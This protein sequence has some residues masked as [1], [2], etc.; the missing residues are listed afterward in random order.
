MYRPINFNKE[1]IR[2]NINIKLLKLKVFHFV[3]IFFFLLLSYNPK[4]S[5]TLEKKE[6]SIYNTSIDYNDQNKLFFIINSLSYLQS[7]KYNKIEIKYNINVYNHKNE[8]IKPSDLALY[9][10]SNIV[11]HINSKDNLTNIIF[12]ADIYQNYQFSCRLYINFNR[13]HFK[14]GIKIYLKN[15]LIQTKYFDS[16]NIIDYNNLFYKN[17]NIFDPL[18]I[19]K[20]YFYSFK[21]KP[22]K[23]KKLAN[24]LGLRKFYIKKPI[25]SDFSKNKLKENIWEFKNF[26]NNYFCICKGPLCFYYNIS[27]ICKYKFYLN[28]IDKNKDLYNK[29]DF[30]LADFFYAR[31]SSDDAYPIFEEMI[32]LNISAHYM[33]EKISLYNKFCKGEKYC[34]KIIPVINGN[35]FIDDKFLEKYL[36]IILRLKAVIAGGEFY[37]FNNIFKAIDYITYINLGHGVKF[38]KNFLYKK[39]S[40]HKKYNKLL[41][42]PSNKIISLAKKYGWDDKNIIKNCLPKWDKYD[43]YREKISNYSNFKNEK[44]IFV[45]F[46][47]RVMKKKKKISPYYLKNIINLINNNELIKSLIKNNITL[48]F[49]LHHRLVSY[50][51]EIKINKL[52][53][54][55]EQNDISNCLRK[56]NLLISDFSSIIFEMIY[57][58]KPYIIFIPDSEDKNIKNIYNEGYYDIINGLKNGSIDFQ[59]KYFKLDEVIN[60]TLSYIKNGF[61]IDLKLSNFYDSF[62]FKCKN[63]T[64]TFINYLINY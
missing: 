54:Y 23:K 41:L 52:I 37:S 45:M 27:K 12:L 22:K 39:Y 18:L 10:N 49:T 19:K 33:D 11:C 53:K 56:T 26:Y 58:R 20:Q 48:Y 7:I 8:L 59:N 62:E 34:L 43:N 21:K 64:K 32:R 47:W 50:K 44:S 35:I 55:I 16:E 30:L 57:Q 25:C 40:S 6:F 9:Y 63:N 29:T 51:K 5:L 60:K 17:D 2:E 38:F 42:P 46:T 13:E 28:I 31:T 14:C 15:L 24:N 4:I 3:I 1:Y 61:L 36:E